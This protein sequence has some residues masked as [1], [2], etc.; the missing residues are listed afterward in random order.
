MNSILIVNTFGIGDVLF[1]TPV[2]SNLHRAYPQ[3]RIVYLANRRT[4][5]FLK[6]N[7]KIHKVLVYERDEFHAVYRRNPLAFAL[8]WRALVE[9]IKAERFD[10]VF[11]FFLNRT[12]V[13]ICWLAGVPMR[14]GY[15]FRGRG[16]F[17][18]HRYPLVRYEGRHVVEYYLDLLRRQDIPVHDTSLEMPLSAGDDEWAAQWLKS[19][20][21]AGHPLLVAMVPGGGASWGKHAQNKRWPAAQY[22]Q[23]ADKVVADLGAAVILIGDAKEEALCQEIARLAHHPF[24]S[25]VGQ[26]SVTQMAA[27][28]KRCRLAI[29][30]DGGPLHVAVAVKTPTIGI[31]GP[32]DDAVYGPYPPAGH[33]VVKLGI[34]CQPCYRNFYVNDCSHS[35][36]LQE[37]SVEDVY[38]KVERK[39]HAKL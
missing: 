26:T 30:N 34:A 22:A 8:K 37:L 24:Y 27:L 9:E 36:C 13:S 3:A 38:K 12:F 21:I 11:N 7:P 2:I 35:K 4:A 31:F 6:H 33:E 14:V 32:V 28:F 25:A 10:A 39:V 1:T 29:A 18:T 20:S 19:H 5:E 23:L 16:Q 17:L 15:D